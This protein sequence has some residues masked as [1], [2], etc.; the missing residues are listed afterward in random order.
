[1]RRFS[2]L[3]LG[4]LL[5]ISAA[6]PSVAAP[7]RTLHGTV[8]DRSGRPIQG[9]EVEVYQLGAGQVGIYSVGSGGAFQIGVPS[10][11]GTL[12]QM[13]VWAKG[14]RTYESGW[15]D[16]SAQ[17]AH[18]IKLD[19][20]FGGLQVTLLDPDG[21][22]LD[23]TAWL[24][25]PGNVLVGQKAVERGRL[26]MDGLSA[27]TYQLI[28]AAPDQAGVTQPV[29]IVP[30]QTAS[31]SVRLDRP[32]VA[33]SGQVVSAVTR[34]PVPGARVA[35]EGPDGV[36]VAS[37]LT[38]DQGRF[39]LP[40]S[41]GEGT[42]RLWVTAS[43]YQPATREGVGLALGTEYDFSG[44]GALALQPL[45]GSL[46]GVLVNHHG[47]VRRDVRVV[48]HL[49]G[50]GEVAETRT[51]DQGEFRFEEVFAG[52]GMRYRLTADEVMDGEGWAGAVESD[53]MELQPGGVVQT[54]LQTSTWFGS[55]YGLTHLNGVVQTP[56]GAPIEGA[57]VE[58]I[59]RTRVEKSTETGADGTFSFSHISGTEGYFPAPYAIRISKDG[60][61]ATREVLLGGQPQTEIR[62][63]AGSRPPL[64][65]V[66]YPEVSDL[67]GRVLDAA[68]KPLP[69]ATVEL[70]GADGAR[71]H[72]AVT[73]PQ[74][75]YTL[76]DVTSGASSGYTLQATAEGDSTS[77][78]TPVT[79]QVR[80]GEALPTIRLQPATA[81]VTGTV[82]GHNGNLIRAASVRLIGEGGAAVH[83][84]VSDV[85][86]IFRMEVRLPAAGPLLLQVEQQG[87]QQAAVV[88]TDALKAGGSA[89]QDLVLFPATSILEGTLQDAS[90]RHLPGVAV[91]LL[92]EGRGVIGTAVTDQWGR[93]QFP[94]VPA[95]AGWVWVRLRSRTVSFGG[96]QSHG[97]DSV[98]LVRL[99]PGERRVINLLVRDR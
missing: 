53:W 36:Q 67:R 1:M 91:E 81:T 13:R 99:W 82:M 33:V 10:A 20:L 9:A 80:R 55:F 7:G 34:E 16:P 24:V 12:W 39:S 60:F 49:Q 79:E 65:A 38:D 93:Y 96:S 37:G 86:A 22:R 14:Y 76:K 62:L 72:S 2:G 58:L 97:T 18:T 89:R 28:L 64:R 51:S 45:I 94:K 90:G 92:A 42:Y 56:S 47:H 3:L 35:V 75:W 69:D 84:A 11:A 77:A 98:P 41:S 73:G 95:D 32:G 87:W 68:G 26:M 63:P 61:V 4:I 6:S 5:L 46:A 21:G 27:G 74:G 44:Q 52:A 48:L 71:L 59:R 15:F 83:E 85:D 66:L 29:R 88:L 50:Y 43:G 30:D 31:L 57:K 78:V 70:L 54:L 40:V 19:S 25:G 23:G 8:T 17:R